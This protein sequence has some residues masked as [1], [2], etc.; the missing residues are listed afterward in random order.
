MSHV[1]VDVKTDHTP[2]PVDGK[3]TAGDGALSP[4]AQAFR[5]KAHELANDLPPAGANA[6]VSALLQLF[7]ETVVP[8]LTTDPRARSAEQSRNVYSLYETRR[9]RPR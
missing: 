4:A 5:A 7:F 1:P 2:V 9:D 8:E 6:L 3:S